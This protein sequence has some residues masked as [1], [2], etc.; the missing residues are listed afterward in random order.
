MDTDSLIYIKRNGKQGIPTGSFLG[1]MTNELEEYGEGASSRNE[2]FFGVSCLC[3]VCLRNVKNFEIIFSLPERFS[4]YN[5]PYRTL[6][7]VHFRPSYGRN[8]DFGC[9]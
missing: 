3:F 7:L 6:K 4:L 1:Q 2:K 8:G 9:V 5:L